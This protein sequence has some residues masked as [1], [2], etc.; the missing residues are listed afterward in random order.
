MTALDNLLIT[1]QHSSYHIVCAYYFNALSQIVFGFC[2]IAVFPLVTRI[3][4]TN[5]F[6]G[7]LGFFDYPGMSTD[8]FASRQAGDGI[9]K[10]PASAMTQPFCIFSEKIN[11]SFKKLR[12]VHS[13]ATIFFI[14]NVFHS[15]IICSFINI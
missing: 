14:V 7:F 11:N 3:R 5:C 12:I 1:K 4:V 10:I 8:S 15:F 2:R 9:R 13:F 6:L